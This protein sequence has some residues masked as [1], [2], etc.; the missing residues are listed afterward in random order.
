VAA[1][2]T[3]SFGGRGSDKGS[4]VTEKHSGCAWSSVSRCLRNGRV[5]SE[6]G[7]TRGRSRSILLGLGWNRAGGGENNRRR[8]SGAPMAQP[9]RVGEK[10]GR[11]NRESGR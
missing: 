5:R 6:R 9:F 7:E 10:M 2:L 8:L 1:V 3:D 11:G 4:S